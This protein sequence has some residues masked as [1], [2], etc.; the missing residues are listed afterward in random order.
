MAADRG[1]DGGSS[2]SGSDF[3]LRAFRKDHG[4][5]KGP[6]PRWPGQEIKM[7]DEEEEDRGKRLSD[8]NARIV[9]AGRTDFSGF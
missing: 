3:R 2:T 5:A 1:I 6:E 9:L 4:G 7:A 8:G